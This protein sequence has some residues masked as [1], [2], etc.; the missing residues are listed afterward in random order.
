MSALE[1]P[2]PDAGVALQAAATRLRKEFEGVG[3]DTVDQL[4]HSNYDQLASAATVF[5]FLPLLA[6]RAVRQELKT[7]SASPGASFVE[8]A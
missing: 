2:A 6:E 3:P 8:I 1:A 7:L 4:L 5:N